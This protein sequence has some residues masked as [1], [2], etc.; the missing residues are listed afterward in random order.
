[1]MSDKPETTDVLINGPS[2]VEI[3]A[4]KITQIVFDTLSHE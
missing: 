1:M 4:E 2:M 3:A